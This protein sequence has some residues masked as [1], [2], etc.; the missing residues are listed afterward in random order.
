MCHHLVRTVVRMAVRTLGSKRYV[1]LGSNGGGSLAVYEKATLVNK[2]NRSKLYACVT[3]PAPLRR[4]IGVKQKYNP[5]LLM[6]CAKLAMPCL[7]RG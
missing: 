2:P 7:L 3:V 5:K 6:W 4:I 1:C